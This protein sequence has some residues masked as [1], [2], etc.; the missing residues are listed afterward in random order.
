MLLHFKIDTPEAHKVSH[1]GAIDPFPKCSNQL[2]IILVP[3]AFSNYE[4]MLLFATALHNASDGTRPIF[5]YVDERNLKPE[6]TDFKHD[7]TLSEAKLLAND[8]SDLL[9][10]TT[11]PCM[12]IGY[13]YGS[14]LAGM[15]APL[16][17]DKFETHLFLLD[18][19]SPD[20]MRKH[21][22][23]K[24]KPI[25]DLIA[26]VK[27]AAKLSG[28]SA[29]I[30]ENR[31]L[32]DLLN[33]P[34]ARRLQILQDTISQNA[35]ATSEQ[36]DRFYKLNVILQEHLTNLLI[37]YSS[38]ASNN[39]INATALITQKTKNKFDSTSA[40]WESE[41]TDLKYI[42]ETALIESEHQSLLNEENSVLLAEL[43]Q[44]YVQE[45]FDV[46][47]FQSALQLWVKKTSLEIVKLNSQGS[48]NSPTRSPQLLT[49]RT[50]SSDDIPEGNLSK[51]AQSRAS[52]GNSPVRSQMHTPRSQLSDEMSDTSSVRSS[53][54]RSS[55][56]DFSGSEAISL[57]TPPESL[58]S[59][60]SNHPSTLFGQSN[61]GA[62]RISITQSPSKRV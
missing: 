34:L 7:S 40:G 43:I 49:P 20:V 1:R 16:L 62:S 32:D 60:P 11:N 14:T 12:I 6:S 19:A 39:K 13:S 31:A 25:P 38:Y 26:L 48:G 30:D 18:G 3:G 27:Y 59:S 21:L 8:I 29:T 47:Y 58:A 51:T 52:A 22:S 44:K 46:N 33:K 45:H 50:Q 61:R 9:Q 4:D 17:Q 57:Q 35:D 37:P 10:G 23:Q 55:S 24:A 56:G 15:A 28:F 5:I 53:H 54:S 2:P 41:F 42:K 36:L